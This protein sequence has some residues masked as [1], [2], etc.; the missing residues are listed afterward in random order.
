MATRSRSVPPR[1]R[2]KTL[3]GNLAQ[4]DT[5]EFAMKNLTAG[6][7]N[8][9]VKKLGGAEAALSFLSHHVE[10]NPLGDLRTEKLAQ[11]DLLDNQIADSF[12]Y[13]AT[14]IPMEIGRVVDLRDLT[15][16][17][18]DL[19]HEGL[20]T[21]VRNFRTLWQERKRLIKELGRCRAEVLSGIDQEDSQ[22]LLVHRTDRK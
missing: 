7:L 9:I 13:V 21:T 11:L 3:K 1:I 4:G 12:R 20:E 2:G 10:Y 15:D 8:A 6:Q 19:L 14:R 22:Q 18:R 5:M 17:E 16:W